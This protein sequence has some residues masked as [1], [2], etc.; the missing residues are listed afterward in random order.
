MVHCQAS[1][2]IPLSDADIESG[3]EGQ[4]F[5]F[6]LTWIPISLS[7]HLFLESAR[8]VFALELGLIER[9]PSTKFSINY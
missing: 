1:R 3:L 5:G 2:T 9:A 6:R 4:A 8:T 7:I